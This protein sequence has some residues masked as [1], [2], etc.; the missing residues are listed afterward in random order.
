MPV[1]EEMVGPVGIE[2][3]TIRLKV[4]CSTAELQAPRERR[5]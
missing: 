3:T 4:E 1:V 5:L 2:P